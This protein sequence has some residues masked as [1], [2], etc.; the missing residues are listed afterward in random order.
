MPATGGRLETAAMLVASRPRDAQRPGY[1][2]Q[3]RPVTRA[4]PIA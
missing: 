2:A 4:F 1:S 3:G